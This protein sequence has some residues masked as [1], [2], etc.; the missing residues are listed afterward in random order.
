MDF[1]F[2]TS[3]RVVFLSFHGHLT[4]IHARQKRQQRSEHPG[5]STPLWQAVM[6]F[7]SA[8]T[9]QPGNRILFDLHDCQKWTH[10]NGP[11]VVWEPQYQSTIYLDTLDENPGLQLPALSLLLSLTPGHTACFAKCGILFWIQ[12]SNSKFKV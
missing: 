5:F 2:F 10:L 11:C 4:I 6:L 3:K 8:A 9:F 1:F 7:L 12:S